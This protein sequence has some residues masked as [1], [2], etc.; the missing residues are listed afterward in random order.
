M[1]PPL[2]LFVGE[3]MIELS[4]PEDRDTARL[5]V[6]GD[7][8][9]AAIYM[10][11]ALPPPARIELVTALGQDR[12]SDRIEAFMRA[13]GVGCDRVRRDPERGP[14]LYAIETD[15]AGERSFAYWRDASAARR[16][17]GADDA[18]DFSALDGASHVFLSAITLAILTPAIRAALLNRLEEMRAEGVTICFDSNYRPRLWESVEAARA[19]VA[20]AWSI[21]DIGFPSIDDE[22]ALFGESEA[23]ATRR[24]RGY[25]MS[26]CVLK[27]GA[28]GPLLLAPRQAGPAPDYARA[29]R[30]VDTTGAGDAFDGTFL[31]AWLGWR[32]T[33]EALRRAHE[34]ASR[35]VAA[36]GAILPDMAEDG[37]VLR[38]VG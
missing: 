34:M 9:N 19:S 10:R 35:V 18:P 3:P 12:F 8:L 2:V 16:M 11:R 20:R 26:L 38:G 29:D 17:F 21:T 36:P 4:V 14:G 15:A 30:V 5:G 37:E 7:V 6:A 27:R 1:K 28:E 25:G 32:G 23:E 13:H 33:R 22:M 24:L 31:G